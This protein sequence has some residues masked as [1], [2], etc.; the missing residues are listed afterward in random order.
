MS[1]AEFESYYETP[2]H[3]NVL[4]V[5][6]LTQ[7]LL[8]SRQAVCSIEYIRHRAIHAHDKP[9]FVFHA[10]HFTL[11]RAVQRFRWQCFGRLQA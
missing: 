10:I 11:D 6:T 8:S 7:I 5:S 3:M 9:F 2:Y 4:R 1:L